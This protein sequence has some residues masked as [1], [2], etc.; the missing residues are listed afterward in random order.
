VPCCLDS[1]GVITLGNIYSEDVDSILHSKR[2]ERMVESF[3]CRK[4][5]EE[6]CR[7]CGYAQRFI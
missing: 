4:A 3:R 7:R 1:N 2:A 6:L 5:S